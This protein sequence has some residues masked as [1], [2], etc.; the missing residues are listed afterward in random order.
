MKRPKVRVGLVK[1]VPL[2]WDLEANW[3]TFED[4]AKDAAERGADLICT[5]ECFLDGYVSE[6]EHGSEGWSEERFRSISQ[7]LDGDN[8]LRRAR[9]FAR[10]YGVYIIFGFSESAQDGIYNS[11]AL[12]DRG[13]EI[14]GC[15]HKTHLLHGENKRFLP[16]EEIPVWELD[17]GRIGIMICMDRNFPEVARTLKIRGA[18]LIMIPSY[19]GWSHANEWKVLTRARDNECFICFAH[20]NVAF[21][22]D[23]EPKV[24]AKLHSNLPGV[25][26]QDIDLATIPEVMFPHRRPDIY[27]E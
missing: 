13:G 26:V 18:E 6:S 1:A 14:L 25:L 11:A 17:V 24:V 10:K 22:A 2:A 9:D 23:P 3:Q 27:E 4:L 15:Y 21:V 5:P 20:T 8:Y 12:I 16:G 7:S 19:G